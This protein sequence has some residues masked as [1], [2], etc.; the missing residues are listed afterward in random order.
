MF[1]KSKINVTFIDQAGQA[2]AQ[3][4]FPAE[5]LPE[6]FDAQTTIE[7]QGENWEVL[8]AEPTTREQ[9]K[10]SGK[11]RLTLRKFQLETIPPG[12]ILYSTPSICDFLPATQETGAPQN[13]N[14]FSIHED[15][16]R[17]VELIASEFGDEAR[18]GLKQIER[19]HRECKVNN[20]GWKEIYV[21]KEAASPLAGRRIP[22]PTLEAA[23]KT[24][25][26]R[27]DGLTYFGVGGIVENSFAFKDSRSLTVYGTLDGD[28]A[29]T[30][31]LDPFGMTAVDDTDVDRLAEF[32]TTNRLALIHWNWLELITDKAGL[33]RYF[34]KRSAQ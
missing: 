17:G 25:I 12:D 20:S 22:L 7:L 9:A 29:A 30:I 18:T 10:A 19:I 21:R 1:W 34:H 13:K 2:F 27:F 4:D 16:W 6:S 32:L 11:L 8:K 5:S 26:H 33:D 3:G 28:N 15:D 31:C 24:P 23:F 14:V